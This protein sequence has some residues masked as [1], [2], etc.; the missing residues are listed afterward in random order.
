[1]ARSQP[2]SAQG[3][4]STAAVAGRPCAAL[5]A[6]FTSRGNDKKRNKNLPGF[7]FTSSVTHHI[8]VWKRVHVWE[9]AAGV[10]LWLHGA[11]RLRAWGQQLTG[12]GHQLTSVQ[13]ACPAV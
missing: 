12:H 4:G 11:G 1:M 3:L 8:P 13:S 9:A 6:P 7:F 2:W 5:V 10:A